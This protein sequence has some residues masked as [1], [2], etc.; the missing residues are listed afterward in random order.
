MSKVNDIWHARGCSH[1]CSHIEIGLS[2]DV[3]DFRFQRLGGSVVKDT[4]GLLVLLSICGY[5]NTSFK[6]ISRLIY[7]WKL[8]RLTRS[9]PI[10]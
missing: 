2:Q 7:K 1:E 6:G 5:S 3:S 4:R 10:L 8:T 9:R